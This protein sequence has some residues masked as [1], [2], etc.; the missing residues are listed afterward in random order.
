MRLDPCRTASVRTF[1]AEISVGDGSEQELGSPATSVLTLAE[2]FELCWTLD[3]SP[4]LWLST[5]DMLGLGNNLSLNSACWQQCRESMWLKLVLVRQG[6]LALLPAP[7]AD[8][9][10]FLGFL[11]WLVEK[12][13]S[14]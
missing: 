8:T 10:K 11:L 14:A 9:F 7:E 1:R 6:L 3:L 13:I 2:Q 5:K 12:N 4:Q